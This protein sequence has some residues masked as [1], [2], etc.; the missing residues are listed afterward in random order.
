MDLEEKVVNRGTFAQQKGWGWSYKAGQVK[1]SHHSIAG[2]VGLDFALGFVLVV[3]VQEGAAALC[4][5]AE[6]GRSRHRSQL[7][8]ASVLEISGV[9]YSQGERCFV[10]LSKVSKLALAEHRVC[11]HAFLILRGSG[12][13]GFSTYESN[14][15]KKI[16]FPQ[17]KRNASLEPKFTPGGGYPGLPVNPCHREK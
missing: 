8:P 17:G 15:L 5:V 9:S 14:Q 2:D 11:T 3:V 7:W 1:I 6:R 12:C 10:C 13:I 16:R 4:D